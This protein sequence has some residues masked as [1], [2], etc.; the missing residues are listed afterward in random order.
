MDDAAIRFWNEEGVDKTFSH[1][2]NGD[3]LREHLAPGS[4][5]LE[6]GCGY[7]RVA[8]VLHEQ[9]YQVVGVDVAGAMLEKAR[10]VCPAVD[11][12][13]IG[14][15]ADVPFTDDAFDAAFLFGVLTCIPGDEDQRA[16]LAELRRVVRP[17]GL[18]YISV[19]RLQTDKRNLD[20]YA[21]FE[22]QY[23]TYGVFE[24]SNGVTFRHHSREWI[25]TL[26]A[27]WE[28]LAETDFQVTT[29]NGHPAAA[30]QWLGRKP[31]DS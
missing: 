4:R 28:P 2:V 12:L 27:G 29:M 30:F 24:T 21:R 7:G 20:R 31:L 9:G 1:P 22:K 6:Y 8:A 11:F 18:L 15:A 10:R 3:W 26:V 23:E 25:D 5:V 19:Y 14:P 13:Q 17:G 16:V